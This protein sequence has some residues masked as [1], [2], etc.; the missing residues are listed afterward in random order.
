[1]ANH[2][3]RS[4]HYYTL[5]EGDVEQHMLRAFGKLW[6]VSDF[7]GRVLPRDVGKRVYQVGDILQVENDE[8]RAAR[9]LGQ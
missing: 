8:Q 9:E 5:T 2:P 3:H 7:M 1:M 4:R 6:R